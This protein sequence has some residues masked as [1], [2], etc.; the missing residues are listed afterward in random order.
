MDQSALITGAAT[1]IGRAIALNL[2]EQGVNVAVHYMNSK[3]E[4]EEVVDLAQSY[5]VKAC[6]LKANLLDDVE[7]RELI[8]NA[9]SVLKGTLNILVNNASIFEY[10]NINSEKMYMNHKSDILT[11]LGAASEIKQEKKDNFFLKYL[12]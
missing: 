7:L 1:R 11:L 10:D 9:V 5:G 3:K 2:A 4:A 8:P 12:Y 6:A